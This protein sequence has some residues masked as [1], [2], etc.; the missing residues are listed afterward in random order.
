MKNTG[1]CPKCQSADILRVPGEAGAWQG[2]SNLIG[3]GWS[4]FALV[5]RFVCC[6]CGYLEEWVESPDDIQKLR[7]R[8]G[9]GRE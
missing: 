1:A 6:G 9:S 8:Y 2:T 4:G 3:T 7:E 5:S